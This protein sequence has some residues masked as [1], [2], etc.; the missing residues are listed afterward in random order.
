MLDL[1]RLTIIVPDGRH[2][3]FA[4]PHRCDLALRIARAHDRV[5]HAQTDELMLIERTL[6]ARDQVDWA[7]HGEI[8]SRRTGASRDDRIG[9]IGLGPLDRRGIAH[10]GRAGFSF[11]PARHRGTVAV[12][13]HRTRVYMLLTA[14]ICYGSLTGLYLL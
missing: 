10:G 2:Q 6:M 3:G 4:W 8:A 5:K 13:L 1:H 12:V 7:H 9:I 14:F 11:L